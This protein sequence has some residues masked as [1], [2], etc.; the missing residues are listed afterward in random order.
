FVEILAAQQTPS[1]SEWYQGTADAVRKNLSDF[2]QRP[3]EYFIILSGDQLYRMDY[4]KV[5]KQHIEKKSDITIATIP[6]D[7]KAAT[8]FGIMHTDAERKI[9]RFEEKPKTD[10]LL[11]E[12]TI[13]GPLLIEL[14]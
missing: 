10:A 13:P 3:Y 1:G 6:V 9:I 14:G 7:R 11:D 12:L 5:L 2:L 8:D 4:R